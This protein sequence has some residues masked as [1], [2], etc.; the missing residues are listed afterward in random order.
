M[1]RVTADDGR[2]QL[3]VPI[4]SFVVYNFLFTWFCIVC[5]T[6]LLHCIMLIAYKPVIDYMTNRRLEKL[7]KLKKLNKQS[8]NP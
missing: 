5:V 2:E 1:F 7:N 8:G 6:S 4:S 3:L